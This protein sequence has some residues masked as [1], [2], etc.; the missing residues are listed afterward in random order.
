MVK[1]EIIELI[2]QSAGDLGFSVYE[3]G[4]TVRGENT[5]IAVKLDALEG[6]TLENCE[7]YSRELSSRLDVA[8]LVPNYTLEVSSPGL[9][10]KLQGKDDF[11]RFLK[12]PVK[13]VMELEDKRDT[14]KG[15]LLEVT[16]EGLRVDGERGE[17]EI[18][19]DQIVQANLD[20]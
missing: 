19:F 7:D 6:I 11:I 1:D 18:S 12:A 5:H 10:R 9:D 16:E 20:Y 17:I 8:E 4:L 15:S 2:E 13:I 14:I 3:Y